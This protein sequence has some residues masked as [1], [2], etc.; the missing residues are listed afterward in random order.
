MAKG[1]PIKLVILVQDLEF[2][3]TQR[4]ALNL[5]THLDCD[6]FTAELWTLRG[7]KHM[8]GLADS[9]NIRVVHLTEES[10]VGPRAIFELWSRLRRAQP[11]V[12]YTLTVIPN[13]WGR[14]LGTLT[15]VP[16]IVSSLRN[17]IAPQYDK[18]LWHLSTKIICNAESLRSMM[19]EDYSVD[20]DR[21]VTIPNGVDTD[22]F[23]PGPA[24]VSREPLVVFVGRLVDQKD[25]LTLLHAFRLVGDRLPEARLVMMGDG[26]LRPSLEDFVRTNDLAGR[27]LLLPGTPD[28]LPYLR[29]ARVF[30]LPSLY[31]GSPNAMIEAMAAGVPIAATRV[32]GVPEIV[33][34]GETGFLVQPRDPRAL[35]DAL[36]ALLANARMADEMGL[37]ARGKAVA[38]H[39]LTHTVRQAEQVFLECATAAG[40]FG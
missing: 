12:L 37:R 31:E 24:A 1:E 18:W 15:K 8:A 5:L 17:R 27:A 35:A 19:I 30:A 3:G 28:I 9:G 33:T 32:D 10:W 23:C 6:R 11:D 38:D 40:L 7:G 34:D 2:G 22:Y 21:I 20:P 39:S 36:C 29:R 14:L 4:Y 25:P 26:P 16:V 13:T